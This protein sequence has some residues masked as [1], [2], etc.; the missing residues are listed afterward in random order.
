MALGAT[1]AAAA[2]TVRGRRG[3]RLD[4]RAAR[5]ARRARRRSRN[6]RAPEGFTGDAARPTRCAAT[7]GSAFLRRWGL[8]ACLADDMGLGK[9]I[10]TLALLQRD[11]GDGDGTRAR[12][13]SSARRRC[14]GNWQT[15]AA[16]FTPE[17]P[18]LVHHGTGA[19]A[20][21]RRSQQAAPT[22]AL[23]ISSYAL[24]HRDLED[25]QAGAVGGRRSSTRRRTSRT[26]R[27]SRPR[28]R[29][30]CTADYRIAL[31]GTP[32]ENHV[33]DLWS[34]M[35]FL[36]PGFLGTQ[37]EFKRRLLRA[38]PGATATRE[39]AERL[40]RLTGPFILRRLKTDRAI[41]ADLPEKLEMKVFCT[42]TRGAGVALRAGGRGGREAHR[43]RRGH[44]AHGA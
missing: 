40:Q 41:I 29:A 23:V 1:R 6:C 18:V 27:P 39:A 25:L 34:I 7:P 17:L 44:R 8:G 10:Q 22:H 5:A 20:R 26:P 19:Q 11:C 14:V 9:T 24:L 16:R 37:A 28:P 15:E 32:V 21:R 36:N 33:G 4:R 12:C 31:T 38:D 30:R 13:C 35:E 2:L 3:G 43:R 42:L